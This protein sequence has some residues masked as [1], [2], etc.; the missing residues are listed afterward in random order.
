MKWGMENNTNWEDFQQYLSEKFS[1]NNLSVNSND[2][3]I[4]GENIRQI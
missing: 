4:K 2:I 3:N 1:R